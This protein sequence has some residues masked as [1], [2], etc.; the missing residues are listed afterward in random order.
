MNGPEKEET[1]LDMYRERIE[2]K[3]ELRTMK[4]K[5]ERLER[6]YERMKECFGALKSKYDEQERELEDFRARHKYDSLFEEIDRAREIRKE[7]LPPGLSE[8]AKQLVKDVRVYLEFNSYK[9]FYEAISESVFGQESGLSLLLTGIYSYLCGIA[10]DG[11]PRKANLMLISP[12][13]SGKTETLRAI[14]SYFRD[15]IKRLVIIH[16]DVSNVSAAGYKGRET[17][18]LIAGLLKSEGYGLAF[19]SEFDKMI[20]PHH[21]SSGENTSLAVIN[22]FLCMLEGQK[23][24]AVHSGDSKCG[25]CIDTNN[26]LFICD[27]SFNEIREQRRKNRET[28][29]MGFVSFKAECYDTYEEITREDLIDYGATYELLGRIPV[30]IQYHKL[31]KEAVLGVIEKSRRRI[32]DALSVEV[33][34]GTDYVDYLVEQANGD[35]GVRMIESTI[36]ND[37]LVALRD[38]FLQGQ[39]NNVRITLHIGGYEVCEVDNEEEKDTIEAEN[40]QEN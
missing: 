13:G 30:I 36:Y 29:T 17:I 39:G 25:N 7:E 31:S 10:R 26:T 2:L 19:F 16:E 22:E 33:D 11:K 5:H 1:M 6:K 4:S 37:S 14:T 3:D 28:S 40:A 34:F 35:Y 8:Y 12:S 9:Q 15:K 32:S 24:Y 18:N 20:S 21:S 27:G 38:C 23:Y